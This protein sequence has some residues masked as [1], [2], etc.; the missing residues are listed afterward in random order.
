M[1]SLSETNDLLKVELQATINNL[2]DVIKNSTV[3][4]NKKD[5]IREQQAITVRSKGNGDDD[6][7]RGLLQIDQL[8]H[9]LQKV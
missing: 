7:V 3:N 9:R 5:G 4:E 2:L 8:H 1:G 6:I